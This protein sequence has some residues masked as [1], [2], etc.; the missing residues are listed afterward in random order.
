M[1]LL[2]TMLGMIEILRHQG[3]EE[4]RKLTFLG[5]QPLFLQPDA[6]GSPGLSRLDTFL[7]D[8]NPLSRSAEPSRCD[9]G[10]RAAEK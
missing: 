9:Q 6:S 2:E 3:N 1:L 5:G 8:L 4:L 7:P 10:Q